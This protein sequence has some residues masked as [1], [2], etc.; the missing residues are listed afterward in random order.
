MSTE[1]AVTSPAP[2]PSALQAV[3]AAQN[4]HLMLTAMADQKASLL[5]LAALFTLGVSLSSALHGW[6]PNGYPFIALALTSLLVAILALR[7]LTPR[8]LVL[9]QDDASPEVNLLFCGHFSEIPENEYVQKLRQQLGSDEAAFELLAR[10]LYQMG[11]VLHQTK[12]RALA[13]AL[14][15]AMAGL[16]VT[17]ICFITALILPA[18]AA[19]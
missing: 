10:D 13:L 6:Q 3:R 5:L 1:P 19:G 16:V 18:L 15:T 8:L 7:A 11:L 12:L 17:F 4:H 9:T 2:L 14:V